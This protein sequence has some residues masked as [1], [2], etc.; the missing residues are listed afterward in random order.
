MAIPPRGSR[1]I[2]VRGMSFRWRHEAGEQRFVVWHVLEEGTLTIHLPY[3]N[4][5]RSPSWV[6]RAVEHALDE[7][8]R[9]HE[10]LDHALTDDEWHRIR[11]SVGVRP[12]AAPTSS[13]QSTAA[14]PV[15]D[16]P[17]LQAVYQPPGEGSVALSIWVGSCAMVRLVV[18]HATVELEVSLEDESI[19]DLLVSVRAV[20]PTSGAKG[21]PSCPVN[22]VLVDGR[23]RWESLSDASGARGR[24]RTA[25]VGLW[26]LGMRA[27]A[28]SPAAMEALQGLHRWV[29]PEE[30]P[31]VIDP[32]S[33]RIAVFG[34]VDA[35]ELFATLVEL[36]GPWTV[37]ARRLIGLS[38]DPL[39]LR[40]LLKRRRTSFVW[41]G[42]SYSLHERVYLGLRVAA[43]ERGAVRL[44]EEGAHELLEKA[45][46]ATMDPR[47]VV[48]AG[49]ELTHRRPARRRAAY[50]QVDRWLGSDWVEWTEGPVAGWRFTE[51][52]E[53]WQTGLPQAG[54]VLSVRRFWVRTTDGRVFTTGE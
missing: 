46:L 34:T 27:F 32:V 3:G 49:E 22:L 6:G 21:P 28:S 35:A 42:Q 7:G 24:V 23:G 47:W 44:L 38:G 1:P 15:P 39:P 31:F 19:E 13:F 11:G 41:L 50:D 30:P 40:R 53:G 9:P 33:R 10:H 4:E 8:W 51:R 16:G 52:F 14:A 20:M 26:R 43:T 2:V 54:L 36:P 25:T 12:S 18:P 45:L 17:S 29:V 37:D 48:V 5:V